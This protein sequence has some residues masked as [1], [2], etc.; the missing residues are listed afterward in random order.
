LDEFSAELDRQNI[1]I[2]WKCL[3]RVN[4]VK[5][6]DLVKMHTHGC[7]GVEF[8]VESG[9]DSILA[10]AHKGITTAQVREAFRNA[11]NIGL[12]TFGFFIFGLE[13]DTHETIKQTCNFAIEISPDLCGFAVLLPF[14]G[15]RIYDQLPQDLRFEWHM[16]NSYYDKN[17]LP[18]S[19]CE[20][21]PQDLR[22]YAQQADAEVAGSFSYLSKNVVF[23]KGGYR[24]HQKEAF[25]N[26]FRSI[27]TLVAR[28]IKGQRVFGKKNSFLSL[29]VI[30]RDAILL[31]ITGIL[32]VW[33]NKVLRRLQNPH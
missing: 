26:W 8:G 25:N 3:A 24:I 21:A 13:H 2:P 10:V 28:R 29:L 33:P 6:N 20:V 30:F 17:A 7:Y 31:T 27:K 16:F 9:N 23:K 4:S 5:R 19:L 1:E 15:T 14:P 11:K 18:F 32:L 12:L 22:K